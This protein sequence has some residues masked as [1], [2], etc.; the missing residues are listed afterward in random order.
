MHDSVGSFDDVTRH[1]ITW[2]HFGRGQDARSLHQSAEK[3]FCV[4]E[5]VVADEFP[6]IKRLR[7]RL[8]RQERVRVRKTDRGAVLR[9]NARGIAE[10][11]GGVDDHRIRVDIL[12][13]VLPQ[14]VVLLEVIHGVRRRLAKSRY[15]E[16][17]SVVR[18]VDAEQSDGGELAEQRRAE[19]PV[20]QHWMTDEEGVFEASGEVL[21]GGAGAHA[22]SHVL[23][24]DVSARWALE[25]P[26]HGFIPVTNQRKTNDE[27]R[28]CRL[29]LKRIF[30]GLSG[31]GGGVISIEGRTRCSRNKSPRGLNAHLNLRKLPV[32]HLG[33]C[34][35]LEP[36]FWTTLNPL[37][38][39]TICAKSKHA[40]VRIRWNSYFQYIGPPAHWGHPGNCHEQLKFFT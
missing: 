8:P 13:D 9:D 33:V 36:L 12:F 40:F 29:E 34:H 26:L 39:R 16:V 27:W 23:H 28:H 38:I 19:G 17:A 18:P 21:A 6:W 10:E 2:R 3:V 14:L 30:L 4:V 31:G 22:V 11:I 5:K 32:V 7:R 37:P 25:G 35:Q 15:V 24:K 20:C 1:L